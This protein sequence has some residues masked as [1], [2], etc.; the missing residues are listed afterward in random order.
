MA[1]PAGF[2][3]FFSQELL[4]EQGKA[5]RRLARS[6]LRD[7]AEAAD[8]VQETW[9]RALRSPPQRGEGA[10][11]WLR[12]VTRNVAL[13]MRRSGERRD[14]RHAAVAAPEASVASSEDIV[15]RGDLMQ[16]VTQAVMQLD[17]PYRST[18]LLRFYEDRPTAD[19][20]RD[21]NVTEATVRSRVHRGLKML[22]ERLERHQT[23][24]EKRWVHG[25]LPLAGI[26]WGT[27]A[28]TA[29]ASGT[30]STVTSSTVTS[31]TV[32]AGSWVQAALLTGAAALVVG[33]AAWTWQAVR[34]DPT[35]ARAATAA[36]A[37]SGSERSTAAELHGARTPVDAPIDAPLASELAG[38]D[39]DAMAG[40]TQAART[41]TWL[42]EGVVVDANERPVEGARVEY[43]L[44]PDCVP[45]FVLTNPQGA[46]S[47]RSDE[48]I[49]D[50]LARAS[51]CGSS[52]RYDVAA[53]PDRE[54]FVRLRL[55]GEGGEVRGRVFDANGFAL[56]GARIRVGS[57]AR[58]VGLGVA[59]SDEMNTGPAVAAAVETDA[60]GYFHVIGIP[61][62]RHPVLAWA[63]G[64]APW[65]GMVD[66]AAR[67]TT[68]RNLTLAAGAVLSGRVTDESGAAVAGV[69]V[70]VSP[71]D[72]FVPLRTATDANGE[73]TLTG[74]ALGSLRVSAHGTGRFAEHW[75]ENDSSALR[76]WNPVLQDRGRLTLRLVDETG[77]PWPQF[78]VVAEWPRLDRAASSSFLDRWKTRL[79]R[80][81]ALPT[82]ADG[83]VT[84]TYPV[85]DL[86]THL[87]VLG[88]RSEWPEDLATLDAVMDGS[89][90]ELVVRRSALASGGLQFRL[91]DEVGQPVVV[92]AL[93][94]RVSGGSREAQLPF[95][96]DARGNLVLDALPVGSVELSVDLETQAG[97]ELGAFTVRDGE[98]HDVGGWNLPPL[99]TL[100]VHVGDGAAIAVQRFDVLSLRDGRVVKSLALDPNR[101]SVTTPRRE[102][103][104]PSGPGEWTRRAGVRSSTAADD[105]DRPVGIA[106]EESSCS[107]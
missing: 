35:P 37:S 53:S 43:N 18:L 70:A 23:W 89:V 31:T 14:R 48:A 99:G 13:S 10:L 54:A 98:L 20:A 78:T 39:R 76:T 79:Y 1:S 55:G 101:G 25:L 24:G 102:V 28:A 29:A 6:L 96:Q 32:A 27:A 68:E 71:G 47:I 83:R 56:A 7:E 86:T 4:D 45:P 49:V 38:T 58:T 69:T 93:R 11:S 60:G 81:R 72:P 22:R 107:S 36:D 82:D 34:A 8:A 104:T 33:G 12:V 59:P 103:S 97:V 74:L 77:A 84:F 106:L 95:Q 19:I 85:A 40:V 62:G 80:R 66:V 100:E 17:E 87:R 26:D 52:G 92:R 67:A 73:Y 61:P 50:L 5:L 16:T 57:R 41:D 94:A 42:V 2:S 64:L 9:L 15:A 75:F 3:P 105:A 63:P 90:H 65:Q 91:L 44:A 21:Q 51:G 30:M 88:P 46:F